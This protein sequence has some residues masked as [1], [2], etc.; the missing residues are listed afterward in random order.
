MLVVSHDRHLLKAPPDEFLLVADGRVQP[1]D[2]DLDDYSR[3][4]VDYRGGRGR[5]APAPAA[6]A[7]TTDKRA[8]RQ[9][10]GRVRRDWHAPA[11]DE[12]EKELSIL[13]EQIGQGR[14]PVSVT[15]RCTRAARKDELRD[16]LARQTQLKSREAELEG[17]PK[18]P[19]WR[20]WKAWSGDLA[21][22]SDA[23]PADDFNSLYAEPS[24]TD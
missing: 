13:H 9:G 19:R 20:S 1:F 8:Q 22:P 12:L 15:A 21:R 18:M 7:R 11:A 23:V 6:G 17:R 4:L 16:L 2:G 5:N 10:R 14:K 24:L 3:W